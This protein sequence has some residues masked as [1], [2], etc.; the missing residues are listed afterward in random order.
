[1]TVVGVDVGGTKT[2]VVVVD[3]AGTV[4]REETR[5]TPASDGPDAVLELVAR[6]VGEVDPS[7]AARAVGV[8]TAGTVDH[9]GVVRASTDHLAAWTGTPVQA[10]LAHELG[11]PVSVVN[12]V[13]A[14]A[15][16]EAVRGA[17]R[18]STSSLTVA[19]GTGV[20][21][22][23][24]RDG[25]VVA[26][27]RGSF[28]SVGHMPLLGRE[29]RRCPCGAVGHLEAYVAGPQLEQ[30]YAAWRGDRSPVVG[31]REVAARARD[32]EPAAIGL[33]VRAGGELGSVLASAAAV[34]EPEVVVVGGGVAEIGDLLIGPARSAFTAHLNP[35][36]RSGTRLVPAELGVRAAAL[37]AAAA[38]GW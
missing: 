32:G 35:A 8:A 31:L 13:H 4:V 30:Q 7:A 24:V 28:A 18:G 21:G 26:G 15:L 10:R 5:P 16:A 22:G 17:A 25:S 37:G 9:D 19:V 23:Y 6:L 34:L 27:R 2:L 29:P 20:G 33:L 14:A 36:L 1:V 38:A 12:D 11:R 3:D